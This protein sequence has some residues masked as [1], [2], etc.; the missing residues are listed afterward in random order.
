MLTTLTRRSAKPKM[1]TM[2]GS[3]SL[4][5]QTVSHYR[6]LEKL[7]G[8]GM[9]VV[10]KAEDTDLGR[11]VALK[12]LPE[13]L[14]QDPQA[15]ERFRREARA[16]SA[17]NHPNICTI[18]EIGKHEALTFIAMELMEGRTLKHLLAGK[19]LPTSQI[20]DLGTE[21]ADALDAAHSKGIVHRDIKP[22]NLFVT[23]RG[24]AK[25][26]DF[27]LAKV[28]EQQVA[29]GGVA[30][31]ELPTVSEQDLT[32]PGTMLGT[33]AY[34]SPEQARGEI[35]DGRTDL[36]SF[37]VVL[38]E[39]ATGKLPFEGNTSAVIFTGILTQ[40]PTPPARLNPE[41]PP[42]L[43]E[44]ISKTLEKDRRQRY[45]GAA[46]VRA[47]LQRLKRDTESRRAPGSVGE[48]PSALVNPSFIGPIALLLAKRRKFFVA[49]AALITALIVGGL[50]FRFSRP[51]PLT[52]KDT[53]VLTDFANTTADP[54]FDGTL[55]QALATD[56]EQSPFLNILSDNR[57]AEALRLMGRSPG[58]RVTKE[59]GREICLRSGSTVLL[60]GS[61][62]R[63]GNHYP[64]LL[65]A[66]NCE[67][68]DSLGRS[69]GEAISR[70]NVLRV[71]GETATRLRRPLGES[72]ASIQRYNKPLEQLTTASLGALQAATEALRMNEEKGDQASLPFSKRAVEIDPNFAWAYA[73]LGINYRNL[74]ESGLAIQNFKRAF[75]LRDRVSDRERFFICAT[76]YEQAT[77]ELEKSNEQY[78]LWIEEYPRDLLP[79][80]DLGANYAELGDFTKAEAETRKFLQLEVSGLSYA[81]EASA[82]LALDRLNEAKAT[83]DAALSHKLDH[84]N[85]HLNMYMLAFLNGD[86]TEMQRQ[87]VWATGTPGVED[88]FFSA[89]SDT[90]TYHGRL[91]NARGFSQRAVESARR[92][93]A[94]ETAA[95]WQVDAALHE[96]EVGNMGEARQLAS[97]ALRL[98]SGR[99]V[100]A[101][102]ALAFALTGDAFSAQKLAEEL[103]GEFSLSM[104]V[105][106]YWLPTIRA[107]IELNRGDAAKAL[108]LLEAARPYDLGANGLMIPVYVR[109]MAQLRAGNAP[110]AAAEF[111]NILDHRGIVLNEPISALAH[112][113]IAR[114]FAMQG[115]SGK[116]RA[117]YQDFLALWKDGDADIPILKQ[118]KS[119]Y[120]KLQ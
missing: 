28:G 74:G 108:S 30:A 77:G 31:S 119:E 8:G 33:V 99:D 35:L 114:A 94:K 64:I 87:Q 25:I 13:D 48:S 19:P 9:G 24:H 111:Q 58:E 60:A 118:A 80:G 36:F 46:D 93:D 65:S 59:I 42:T 5:G 44:I 41:T 10:Y 116:A 63:L 3:A 49:G 32:S 102:A 61:I 117:A 39:M 53:V 56:L 7:G 84:P 109:G 51:K 67:T 2:A 37:G 66:E 6:I 75:E 47:D 43:E 96:V 92:N 104:I 11:F 1:T 62:G 83:I 103:N 79:Y 107:A 120:A 71:L 4:L 45:Q 101:Q 78:Q 26:L 98:S 15:L 72:I 95:G 14:A 18:H 40:T 91:R 22:A 86:A 82:Y 34:M 85:L 50:Y 52:E 110:A 57:V 29:A 23:N 27:G 73:G 68:G 54:V 69:Q 17:L 16:A 12:F 76:Y 81:N 112:L 105:Q 20:L 21:I 97:A 88:I 115:D 106:R 100:K 89:Q 38:Y 113:Q 90:E 70:E 55:R